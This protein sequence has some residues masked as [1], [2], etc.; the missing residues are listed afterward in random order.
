MA[1]DGIQHG[2]T[3]TQ[4][5]KRWNKNLRPFASIEVFKII[6]PINRTMDYN[7]KVNGITSTNIKILS[8]KA[9]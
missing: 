2:S 8:M 6:Y 4:K 1:I 9:V 3:A 7:L 5:K